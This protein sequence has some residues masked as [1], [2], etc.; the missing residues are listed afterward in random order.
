MAQIKA[1][2]KFRDVISW[3]LEHRM[4]TRFGFRIHGRKK[5]DY[6]ILEKEFRQHP[7]EVLVNGELPQDVQNMLIKRCNVIVGHFLDPDAHVFTIRTRLHN[8]AQTLPPLQRKFINDWME[9]NLDGN[10]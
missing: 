1:R 10:S 9:N 4:C 2:I 6:L 8:I 5:D 7:S 3:D